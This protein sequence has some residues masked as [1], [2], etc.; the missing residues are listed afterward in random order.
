MKTSNKPT[1]SVITYKDFYIVDNRKINKIDLVNMHTGKIRVVKT[2]QSAKWRI[3]R[4]VN[5]ARKVQ[6][7]V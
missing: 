2:V 7:L 3:T 5:L 4:A 6:R 1:M